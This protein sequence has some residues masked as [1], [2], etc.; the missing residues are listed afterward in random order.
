[1]HSIRYQYLHDKIEGKMLFYKHY[2]Y[3]Y[4][5]HTMKHHSLLVY[6]VSIISLQQL[7]MEKVFHNY[8]NNV[9]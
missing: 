7:L 1:M 4:Q 3:S 6:L 9:K 5:W 2:L 8:N